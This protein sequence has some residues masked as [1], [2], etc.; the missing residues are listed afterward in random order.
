MIDYGWRRLNVLRSSVAPAKGAL[1]VLRQVVERSSDVAM[2]AKD[3]A[4]NENGN[5]AML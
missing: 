3:V 4:M 1:R 2:N 5:V